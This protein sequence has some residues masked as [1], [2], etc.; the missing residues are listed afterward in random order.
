MPRNR[1]VDPTTVRI[2]LSEGD[3]IEVKRGLSYMEQER[4]SSALMRSMSTGDSEIGIDWAKHRLLR[5]ESWLTDWSFVGANGKPVPL[6]RASINALDP[7]TAKEINDA[8]DAHIERMDAE[9]K[10]MATAGE[11]GS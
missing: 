1:F 4:I 10:K 9:K 6:S 8:I 7:E 3:W 11:T 5:M 2:D